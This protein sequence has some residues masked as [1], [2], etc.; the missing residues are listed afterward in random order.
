MNP[1]SADKSQKVS[2]PH[3]HTRVFV[4]IDCIAAIDVTALMYGIK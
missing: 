4:V 3:D 2:L 1:V